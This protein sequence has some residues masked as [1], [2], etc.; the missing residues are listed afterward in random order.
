MRK[1][2]KV[3]LLCVCVSTV[4][5]SCAKKDPIAPTVLANRVDSTTSTKTTTDS[6]KSNNTNPPINTGNNTNSFDALN[7]QENLFDNIWWV[8]GA[9]GFDGLNP[10]TSVAANNAEVGKLNTK[11]GGVDI[12]YTGRVLTKAP[13]QAWPILTMDGKIP[14]LISDDGSAGKWL[15]FN[16]KAS[17]Y[18]SSPAVAQIPAPFEIWWVFRILPVATYEAYF[19]PGDNCGYVANQGNQLRIM[20]QDVGVLAGSTA[21]D[22]FTTHIGRLV[23]QDQKSATLYIDGVSQ[24]T[25][26]FNSADV[27][28]MFKRHF[29]LGAITN[30]AD[31][32]FAA[33]YFKKGNFNSTDATSIYNALATKWGQGTQPTNQ[34]LIT[35]DQQTPFTKSGGVYTPAMKIVNVPAGVTLADP[36]KWDYQWYYRFDARNDNLDVQTPFSTKYQVT[37][38]DFPAGYASQGMEIKV[39]IRPKDINGKSWR[40]FDGMMSTY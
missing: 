20:N 28:T 33:M 38:A 31:W 4:L 22:F 14:T 39:L 2:I 10:T 21:P 12:S 6:T 34:I 18:Y 26:N 16:N 27:N 25:Y 7:T 1:T 36:S 23:I 32:D 3:I 24:G 40:W 9:Y 35:V 15:A 29:M 30:N 19:P 8:K 37:S 17:T 5:S 11:K 13:G